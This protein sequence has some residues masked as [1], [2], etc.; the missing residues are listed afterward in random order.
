[1]QRLEVYN[2]FTEPNVRAH[3]PLLLT[4]VSILKIN[5]FQYKYK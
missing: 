1:M 2:R 5:A 4:E 3:S